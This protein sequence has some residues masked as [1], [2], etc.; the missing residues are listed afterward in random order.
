M[1]RRK[2]TKD[3][4][5]LKSFDTKDTKVTKDGVAGV[6]KDLLRDLGVLRVLRLQPIRLCV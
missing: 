5:W 2:D 4:R 1:A 6:E 3:T